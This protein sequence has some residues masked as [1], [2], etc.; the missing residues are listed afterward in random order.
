MADQKISA[1]T[2]GT[3]LSDDDL[4]V[5]VDD[6]GGTPANKKITA[7]NA[8]ASLVPVVGVHAS[9]TAGQAA[10]QSVHAII[11]PDAYL[12]EDGV[13]FNHATGLITAPVAGYYSFSAN[14]SQ[15]AGSSC[16]ARIW[17]N[18]TISGGNVTTGEQVDY[19]NFN[20]SLDD[21]RIHGTLY[22]AANDT[23]A[24]TC[25]TNNVGGGNIT[26]RHLVAVRV[27]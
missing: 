19:F 3:V 9:L 8:R 23:I 1:L 27:R 7:A 13:L 16:F 21:G 24:F 22:L 12:R 5:F 26:A 20:S 17:K 6:P 2:A 4:L 18:P 14:I 25:Q 15:S 11:I 10:A